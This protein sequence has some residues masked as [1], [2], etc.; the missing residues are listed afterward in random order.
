MVN[1]PGFLLACLMCSS[2]I[3]LA[4]CSRL[5]ILKT[6]FQLRGSR[7]AQEVDSPIPEV[8][9]RTSVQ[10]LPGQLL[11]SPCCGELVNAAEKNA[12]I[13]SRDNFRPIPPE[14]SPPCSALE[15]FFVHICIIFSF[16]GNCDS[17]YEPT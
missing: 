17:V 6:S 3:P 14:I 5:E 15:G 11:F 10:I 1:V 7:T 8:L 13:S 12:M 9:R 4:N 2:A 16:S